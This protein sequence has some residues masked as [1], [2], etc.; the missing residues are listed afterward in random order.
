MRLINTLVP[1]ILSD[2]EH[3]RNSTNNNSFEEELWSYPHKQRHFMIIVIS[4]KR[5]LN[6]LDITAIAPPQEG[7]RV[8]VYTSIYSRF[9][10]SCLKV[11]I[12]FDLNF[13]I[14]TAS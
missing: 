3:S 8:G 4:N 13:T 2:F 6:S 7:E 10:S 9:Y 14:L 5:F 12:T 1:E 11:E